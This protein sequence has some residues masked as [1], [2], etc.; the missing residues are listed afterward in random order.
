[1]DEWFNRSTGKWEYSIW[2]EGVLKKEGF[3]YKLVS[4]KKYYNIAGGV[5]D[6]GEFDDNENLYNGTAYGSDGNVK[7]TVVNGEHQ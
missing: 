1:M 4:G 6:E 2:R 5:M 3:T 7:W